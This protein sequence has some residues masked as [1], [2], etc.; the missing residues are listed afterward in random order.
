MESVAVQRKV[1]VIPAKQAFAG[2]NSP[3]LRPKRVAPIAEFRPTERNKSTALKH[4]SKC[5]PT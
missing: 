2:V 1:T 3:D 5:T 4:K